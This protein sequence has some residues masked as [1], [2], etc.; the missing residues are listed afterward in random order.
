MRMREG[1]CTVVM[2]GTNDMEIMSYES[3]EN[4]ALDS[5]Y[6]RHRTRD[7]KALLAMRKT[8]SFFALSEF[9]V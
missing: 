2:A 1:A 7:E 9:A 3:I 8:Y 4:V 6:H 5:D